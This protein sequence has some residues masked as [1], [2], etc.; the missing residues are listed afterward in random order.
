VV[1]VHARAPGLDQR[2]AQRRQLVDHELALGVERPGGTGALGREHPVSPDDL[3]RSL[4][5]HDQVVAEGVEPVDV[6][7]RLI[8]RQPGAELVGED[9]VAQPLGG[10]H[11]VG[12]GGE[13]EGVA[14]RRGLRRRGENLRCGHAAVLRAADD[15]VVA[16]R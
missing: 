10:A 9:A 6:H 2:P 14:G 11:R 16:P 12:V 7:T 5:P 13:H 1:G 8:G 4:L 15:G 3:P